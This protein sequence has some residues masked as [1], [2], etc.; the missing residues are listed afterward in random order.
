MSGK[1]NRIQIENFDYGVILRDEKGRLSKGTKISFWKGK[2]LSV[3]HRRKQSEGER[4]AALTRKRAVIDPET[5]KRANEK[6]SA[7]MKKC[8]ADPAYRLKLTG[9]KWS[10]ENH[11][12]LVKQKCDALQ[13]QGFRCLP[14]GLVSC[15]RPDIIAIKDGKVIAIE[16]ERREKRPSKYAGVTWYDD[17]IWDMQP[18]HHEPWH[19]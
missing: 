1:D 3:E 18:R 6:K 8:W 2:K 14:I 9:R 16:I 10:G 7:S 4:V 15:P 11:D 19:P 13:S 12:S 17:V 5:S